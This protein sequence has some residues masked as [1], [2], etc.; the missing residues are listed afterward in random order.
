MKLEQVRPLARRGEL[1]LFSTPHGYRV[2]LQG[3]LVLA[4]RT[5]MHEAVRE[6]GRIADVREGR[7]RQDALPGLAQQEVMEF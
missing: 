2:V 5:D 1:E 7:V 4:E 3:G 6:F